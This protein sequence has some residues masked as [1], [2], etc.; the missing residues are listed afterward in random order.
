MRLSSLPSCLL[1]TPVLTLAAC[2]LLTGL[3]D[4][5]QRYDPTSNRWTLLAANGTSPGARNNVGFTS[6]PNG[7]IYL[8]GGSNSSEYHT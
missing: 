4:G 6:T 2:P 1:E 3:S 8:Y 5:I 7:T